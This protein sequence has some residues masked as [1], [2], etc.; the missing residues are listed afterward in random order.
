[1]SSEKLE[2]AINYENENAV[3]KTKKPGFHVAARTG[4]M[5]D[6]NGFSFYDGKYHLFYQYHPYETQWGPMHWAHVISDDC[7]HWSNMPTVL[8]PDKEYDSFGCFSG[9]AVTLAD[10]RHLLMYTGVAKHQTADGRELELQNQCLAVGDGVTYEKYEQNPVIEGKDLPAWC[11]KV[12]FRDPKIGV[13]EDGTY[14]CVVGNRPADG[15]GQILLFESQNGFQWN[16]K[17]VLIRNQNRFGKMWECPDFFELDGKWI[18]LTSPQDMLAE[19]GKYSSGN[20]TLCLVGNYN[21]ENGTFS[22][23]KDQPIDFGIDFYAPQTV[24]TPDGRRVM[25]AW[26]QNWDT[27][28][29]RIANTEWFGQMTL[30]RELSVKNGK[31]IQTPI[32][33]IES[34]RTN[35]IVY[36]NVC[37]KG[38]MQYEGI[39]GRSIDME[40]SVSTQ[41]S[42]GTYL[43]IH[44]AED[45]KNYTLVRIDLLRNEVEVN[46][47]YAGVVRSVVNQRKCKIDPMQKQIKMRMIMDRYSV[48]LFMNDGEK[49]MTTTIYTDEKADQISFHTDGE[50]EMSIIKYD[51]EIQK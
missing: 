14:Y 4:W 41:T 32:R 39:Q 12:D 18:L 37:C 16:Y 51:L 3:E 21:R 1:M 6:P 23:E 50:V 8:A 29:Y 26:M 25:I 24:L 19:A 35:K 40:L 2:Q 38:D 27:C 45:S 11:S 31:L 34:I 28:S 13:Y 49:T 43:D 9:S 42:T 48:E 22:E 47:E 17:N 46:R 10:G 33:E 36:E 44:V 30:P 15:S 5:N 20:G 7:I